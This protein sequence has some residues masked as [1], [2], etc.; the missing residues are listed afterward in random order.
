[1]WFSNQQYLPVPSSETSKVPS[2]SISKSKAR[3]KSIGFPFICFTMGALTFFAI[4]KAFHSIKSSS[5]FQLDTLTHTFLYNRSFSYPPSDHTNRAWRNIF[6]QE[7]GFFVHP[8]V[9][10]TR[11][12]FSVFHQLHCLNGIRGAYWANQQAAVMGKKLADED[13]PVDIQPSHVRHCIDLLRQVLMCHG[14][15][16]LEVVDEAINGVHGFRTPHECIDWEQLKAWTSEQQARQHVEQ[17]V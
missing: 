17:I 8:T 6:P 7:G 4:N 9:A 16:T 12:T 10:P 14:D 15:T 5:D 3:F 2:G 1:M 13:L 11:S